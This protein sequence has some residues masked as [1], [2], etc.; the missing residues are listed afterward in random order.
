MLHESCSK[1]VLTGDRDRN[2]SMKKGQ[3]PLLNNDKVENV[4]KGRQLSSFSHC[5]CS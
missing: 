4:D 3:N 5:P 2:E 1:S